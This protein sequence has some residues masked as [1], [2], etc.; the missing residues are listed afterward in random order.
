MSENVQ[1][2]T[3]HV[4]CNLTCCELGWSEWRFLSTERWSSA[5]RCLGR[6]DM[7]VPVDGQ[8]VSEG[9]NG[10]KMDSGT[11]NKMNYSKVMDYSE[12]LI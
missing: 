2:Y 5:L 4:S 7:A 3:P 9:K 10:L 6:G 12:V 1:R 8:K 11:S